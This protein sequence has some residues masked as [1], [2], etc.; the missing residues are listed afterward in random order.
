MTKQHKITLLTLSHVTKWNEK[1]SEPF[2]S[3]YFTKPR[4]HCPQILFMQATPLAHLHFDKFT[5]IN[6]TRKIIDNV[7]FNF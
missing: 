7:F 5:C 1:T 3:L 2:C 4:R 6:F